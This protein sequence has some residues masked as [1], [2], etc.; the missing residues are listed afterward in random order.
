[1]AGERLQKRGS[2]KG[3]YLKAVARALRPLERPGARQAFLQSLRSVIDWRGQR[4]SAL[5]RLHLLDPMPTLIVWGGRD[6]TIPI[7][8]GRDAHATIAGSRFEVLPRAAHFPHLED[9]EGLA[10]VIRDFVDTTEPAHLDDADWGRVI[11]SRFSPR[12]QAPRAVA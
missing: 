5:D 7:A 12:R 2:E 9:P 4:V 1:V 11:A 8:H 6:N 3:V 10:A